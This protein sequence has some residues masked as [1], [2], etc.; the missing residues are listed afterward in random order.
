V[1]NTLLIL[2]ANIRLAISALNPNQIAFAIRSAN[3]F[4]ERVLKLQFG[5]FLC[6]ERGSGRAESGEIAFNSAQ[7]ELRPPE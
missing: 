7:R 3:A 4:L 1:L 6:G 2:I 5:F